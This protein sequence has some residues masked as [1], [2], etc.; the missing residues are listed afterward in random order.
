MFKIKHERTADCVVAGY[1]LHKSGADAIGSLLLGLYTDDGTLGIG[2]R[3]RRVPDGASGGQ[4]FAELQPLVTDVRRPPVELGGAGGGPSH[5]AHGTAGVPAGTRAKTCRSCRCDPS[6]WSRCATTTWKA[7]ASG[8]PRSSTAGGPTA[9]RAR[10]RTSSWSSRSRSP[11]AISCPASADAERAALIRS[12]VGSGHDR[13]AVMPAKE[14]N[15]M[16]RTHLPIPA[17][18]RTGLITYDAKDPDTSYPPI[19]TAASARG[20][21]RTCWSILLDDV[22]FGASSAFGGPVPDADRGAVGGGRLEVQPLSHHRAVFADPAGAADR[23]QP[24]LGG[25]G[26]D[27]RDRHRRAGVQLGA[28][29]HDVADRADAEAQRLQHRAVRQVP[30]GA[31]VAD[32]P[33]RAVRRLAHRRRRFRVLLRLHRRR[34]QPV[35]PDAVRGHQPGRG[36]PAPPKRVT[37]SWRT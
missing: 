36:R 24:P 14:D 21:A 28:A 8:T 30:R 16:Q 31:G 15:A 35:V 9:T 12:R 5:T 32:Q 13:E 17:Q 26:R 3:D 34:G 23:A 18:P 27:H 7:S 37:T 4:L 25:H 29:Q 11:S 22:G 20:C 6:G 19:E 2:R 1:R 33:G 10:A